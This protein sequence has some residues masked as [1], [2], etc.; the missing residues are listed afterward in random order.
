MKVKRQISGVLVIL[1]NLFEQPLD[2]H[3]I[4]KLCRGRVGRVARPRNVVLFDQ[5]EIDLQRAHLKFFTTDIRDSRQ[6]SRASGGTPWP[7]LKIC[8][9]FPR[10]LSR[11]APASAVTTAGV[12]VSRN[13]SRFPCTATVSGKRSR[14]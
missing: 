2:R 8:P 4:A 1:A 7:R 9:R 6:S 5:I 13:G 12:V 11:S 14:T 10:M 3:A